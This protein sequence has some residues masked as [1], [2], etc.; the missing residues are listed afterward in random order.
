MRILLI[1]LGAVLILTLFG[2]AI[3]AIWRARYPS[4]AIEGEV[5]DKS[6]Q[7]FTYSP[8]A[9]RTLGLILVL[10][11]VGVVGHLLETRQGPA[12]HYSPAHLENGKLIPGTLK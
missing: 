4:D 12:E 1:L 6:P 3:K 7:N 5:V 8:L 11:L 9:Q 10:L 2:A